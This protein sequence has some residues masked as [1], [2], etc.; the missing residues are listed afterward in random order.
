MNKYFYLLL[1]LFSSGFSYSQIHEIG[2]FTGGSNFIGDVGP[3]TYIAPNKLAFGVLY[4]WNKSPRHAYRFSYTQ[5]L[6]SANDINSK[7]PSRLQRGFRFRNNIKEFS[8]GL[9]FNFFDFNLH[10]SKLKITPY[11]FSGINYFFHD[12]LYINNAGDTFKEKNGN[13]LA[14][15]MTVGIKSNISRSFVIG[16]EVGARYTFTDNLDGS[17]PSSANLQQFRFGNINN[18]DWYVFSGVTLTYIF[19]EKPCYCAY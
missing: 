13:S 12:E 1:V 18:T 11:V 19:G 14:I 8:A 5:S 9:E 16:L 3:T 17:N 10:E 15:P 6:I 2:V 4:K 7:E